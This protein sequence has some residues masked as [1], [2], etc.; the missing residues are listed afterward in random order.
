MMGRIIFG[1]R[2]FREQ[3]LQQRG[4]VHYEAGMHG[5]VRGVTSASLN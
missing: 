3:R 1:I 4:V 2:A 5:M